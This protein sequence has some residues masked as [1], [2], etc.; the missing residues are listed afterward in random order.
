[1]PKAFIAAHELTSLLCYMP[2]RRGLRTSSPI[3]CRAEFPQI[4]APTN[5]GE[6]AT[7]VLLLVLFK[8]RRQA[9]G[10]A[11]TGSV[12]KTGRVGCVLWEPTEEELTQAGR[13]GWGRSLLKSEGGAG[14]KR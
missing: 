12:M 3:F 5:V 1:M 10:S 11:M 9:D 4:T 6:Q 13:G 2:P 7:A 14:L 8:P